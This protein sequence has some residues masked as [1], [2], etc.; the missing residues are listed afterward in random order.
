MG[1]EPRSVSLAQG[2]K[3]GQPDP[4][5]SLLEL[6]VDGKQMRWRIDHCAGGKS[7]RVAGGKADL[8]LSQ[9]RRVTITMLSNLLR[10]AEDGKRRDALSKDLYLD[11]LR[12][13]GHE[14]FDLLFVGAD[15]RLRVANEL[16]LLRDHGVHMFR[17]K[18]TFDGDTEEWLASLPWEYACTPVGDADLPKNGI[19]LAQRAEL[20]LSRRLIVGLR[21]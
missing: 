6:E 17:I 19:F 10:H 15:L 11:L 18:L 16:N 1:L 14:L 8:Q 3:H 7:Q 12:V 9:R 20:V 4:M 2:P 21:G 13:V 5:I